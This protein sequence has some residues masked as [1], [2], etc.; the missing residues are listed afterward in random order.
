[1]IPLKMSFNDCTIYPEFLITP[2]LSLFLQN[3]IIDFTLRI[4]QVKAFN[5]LYSLS[6]GV[7]SFSSADGHSL[8]LDGFNPST[9]L[10]N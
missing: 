4:A 10:T 5:C 3:G 7:S 1:M 2:C 8:S 6:W 9:T